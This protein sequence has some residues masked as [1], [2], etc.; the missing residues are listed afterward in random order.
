[1]NILK[2]TNALLA[3]IVIILVSS[4]AITEEIWFEKNG[5][6]RLEMNIDMSSMIQIMAMMDTTGLG[7]GAEEMD[8]TIYF[9]DALK[10]EN[11]DLSG[12]ENTD[13]LKNITMDMKISD[14]DQ[15]MVIKM[16]IDF[17][18]LD[19]IPK[20][21]KVMKEVKALRDSTSSTSN[22]MERATSFLDQS[23]LGFT[24]EKGIL[25]RES[26]SL[27]DDTMED[28][29]MSAEDLEMM[30]EMFGEMVYATIIHL[31]GKVKDI[32]IDNAE[33]IQD[34]TV[35]IEYDLLELMEMKEMPGYQIKFKKK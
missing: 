31:P 33:V 29:E 14:L 28:D 23:G 27:D 30:T 18:H 9:E 21:L 32:S 26:Q 20:I 5:S 34:K 13:L 22:P 17:D 25:T 4:C 8:S 24:Y 12:I 7:I 10:D 19:D 3:F 6:G 35:R 1:M 2:L 15:E 11:L 16:N